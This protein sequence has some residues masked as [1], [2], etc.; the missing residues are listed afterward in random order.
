MQSPEGAASHAPPPGL[1]RL[2]HA[3]P[4]PRARS[5]GDGIPSSYSG[6]NADPGIIQ[7]SEIRL[8]PGLVSLPRLSTAKAR[9][10]ERER[11]KKWVLTPRA[12][13]CVVNASLPAHPCYHSLCNPERVADRTIN[14]YHRRRSLLPSL[15]SAINYSQGTNTSPVHYPAPARNCPS[16]EN[17]QV[18]PWRTLGETGT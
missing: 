5:V 15:Q 6:I 7:L 17:T 10:R 12:G 3:P 16:T 1:P 2:A 4:A 14:K 11:E 9:E 13:L 8:T 18:R